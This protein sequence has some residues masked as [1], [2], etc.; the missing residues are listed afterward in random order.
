MADTFGPFFLSEELEEQRLTNL[1]TVATF[2]ALAGPDRHEKRKALYDVDGRFDSRSAAAPIITRTSPTASTIR[3]TL[4]R[5]KER[6]R[7]SLTGG[8][9]TWRSIQPMILTPRSWN[10]TARG[11][12][13]AAKWDEPHYYENHYLLCFTLKDG[14]IK[15]LREVF[16]P[17]NCMRPGGDAEVPEG[18]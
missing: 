16:N 5:G 17:F 2:M 4:M 10:V 11:M 13:Y 18:F 3:K 6:T 7:I 8:I 12:R 14:K 9:T 15:Q 1:E